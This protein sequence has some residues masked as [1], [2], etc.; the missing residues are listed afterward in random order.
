VSAPLA[1][2]TVTIRVQ[3]YV[4][5]EVSHLREI[6]EL[7]Y[8]A[9]E[10]ALN[11]AHQRMEERLGGMNELRDQISRERG[12]YLTRERFD[13]EH[14]TL[15]DRTSALE[16]QASKW[17]GSMWMLGAAISAVVVGVNIL[18]RFWPK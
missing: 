14:V 7:R 10:A 9:S 2:A 8:A 11:M 6:V 5:R 4:D 12:A 16:L 15:Q 3:D 17:S 18:L 13:A 1:D